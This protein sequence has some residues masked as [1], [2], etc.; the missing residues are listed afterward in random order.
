MV[1]FFQ[2]GNK[3]NRHE[4]V[5]YSMETLY[6]QFLSR[7]VGTVV[8]KAEHGYSPNQELQNPLTWTLTLLRVRL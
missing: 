5:T 1:T 8:Q 3:Y 6:F 7:I 4:V 2:N